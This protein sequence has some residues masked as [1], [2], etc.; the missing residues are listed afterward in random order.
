MASP[1]TV[2]T[3][4]GEFTQRYAPERALVNVTVGFEGAKRS[5]VF[6]KTNNAAHMVRGG[7]E[8]RHDPKSGPVVSWVGDSISVWSSKPWNNEGKQLATRFHASIGFRVRFSD[9]SDLA[10]WIEEIAVLDGVTVDSI[11]WELTDPRRT[12]ILAEVRSRAVKD[13]VA[14]AT[15]FAQSIGLGTVRA[16][17]LADPGMLG[18]SGSPAGASF[19]RSAKMVMASGGGGELAFKPE[20]IEVSANVDARFVAS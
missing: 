15:V 9:F 7:I 13:A 6:D 8:T 10:A 16:V 14:K 4:Q 2:I 18:D 17:A 3:V 5:A 12:A 20:D 19:D 1:E 11:N